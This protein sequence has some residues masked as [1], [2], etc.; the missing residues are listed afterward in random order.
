[1]AKPKPTVL[2]AHPFILED[3]R[4]PGRR[5][6]A[7]EGVVQ[8]ELEGRARVLTA[9][10]RADFERKLARADGVITRFS[11][12]LDEA[13]LAKGPRL[14]A[15]G[16]F[17]VGFENIDLKACRK[18][19]IRVAN[20]PDVVTLPTAELALALL[21][22]AARR[23]PE[24]VEHCRSGRFSAKKGGGWQPDL[25]L[26]LTLKGRRAVLVGR[27]RIGKETA[28]LFR[29]I[30]LKVTWITREDSPTSIDRKLARAQILSLH[31]SL[32][33]DTRHWLNAR[34]LKLLPSDAIVIN[35]TRG[36]VVDEKALIRAL[37]EKRIFAAGLD[38]FEREPEIPR[39][40]LELKNAVL[41][42]HLGSATRAT[43]EGMA[44]LAIRGMLALLNGQ[45]PPN[46]VNF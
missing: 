37:R 28:R 41:L 16:N 11:D 5:A 27:G 19:G 30:G 10:D 25:L 43:R 2:L 38:V 6:L 8:R 29:G 45:S 4:T 18:R 31:V 3:G 13:T 7:R 14:R 36:P 26:G 44:R 40:L 22:A 24:G 15:I 42:P 1:M 20:T 32:N 46:E 21:L 34:R 17:A 9:R 23:I 33:Q 35:T 12:R 39:A